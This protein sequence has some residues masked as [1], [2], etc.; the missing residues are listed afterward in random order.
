MLLH[1]AT[2]LRAS[3][4]WFLT[5]KCFNNFEQNCIRSKWDKKSNFVFFAK[6]KI[7]WAGAYRKFSVYYLAWEW[8]ILTM[9][10]ILKNPQRL[11]CPPSQKMKSWSAMD[12]KWAVVRCMPCKSQ[13]GSRHSSLML[14]TS[15][16]PS[17]V[18]FSA[19]EHTKSFYG[20][21]F[22]C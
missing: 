14:F 6:K 5:Q 15:S 7:D 1:N 18:H 13:M 4:I 2:F 19:S 12:M 21:S 11:L 17:I 3:L 9:H 10:F 20:R 22:L 8:L 16:T